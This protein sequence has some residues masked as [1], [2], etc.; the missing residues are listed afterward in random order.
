M[1]AMA[2]ALSFSGCAGSSEP[3]A[4]DPAASLAPPVDSELAPKTDSSETDATPT[5]PN[6]TSREYT[7]PASDAGVLWQLPFRTESRENASVIISVVGN[8]SFPI[9]IQLLDRETDNTTRSVLWPAFR[10]MASPT[11][12]LGTYEV[13]EKMGELTIG[14]GGWLS[15]S[16]RFALLVGYDAPVDQQVSIVWRNATIS[17]DPVVTSSQFKWSRPDKAVDTPNEFSISEGPAFVSDSLTIVAEQNATLFLL[18]G[19]IGGTASMSLEGPAPHDYQV[20]SSPTSPSDPVKFGLELVLA[21][22][23]WTFT[24]DAQWAAGGYMLTMMAPDLG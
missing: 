24:L 5:S 21:P 6:L 19:V 4:D 12:V 13:G 1:M 14:G 15:H 16:G 7:L 2:V 10:E 20:G 23:I 22:G 17:A 8:A 3:T 11:F 18:I 9:E